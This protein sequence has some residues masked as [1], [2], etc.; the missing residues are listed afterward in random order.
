MKARLLSP[1]PFLSDCQRH[2]RR[3]TLV[4]SLILWAASLFYSAKAQTLYDFGFTR[5]PHLVVTTAQ[6]TLSMPW[7]GGMNAVR[8]S[9]IDLN[10]DG[11]LDIIAFEKHG[12]RILPFLRQGNR[13]VFAPQYIHRF[14]RLH[15]W[16]I[17]HDYNQD[18]KAD[19]FTYGLAG[20]SVYKNISQDTLAFELLTDQL[21]AQYYDGPVNI[22]ASPDD[23]PVIADVDGDGRTDILNFWV[24]GKYVH[25]LRNYSTDPDIFDLRLEN[26]CWGH[27]AEAADNNTISLFT[28]CDNKS[29]DE[30]LRHV[31]S[32]LLLHDF[33]GNGLGDLLVGDIDS[34]H[35]I[36]LSNH[37]TPDEARM[38]EQ[39][40]AFPA[41]AP[42]EL[43]SL[44]A[45][46]LVNLPGNATSS[47][48]V[49][50][51]DPSLTKSQDLNSVWRYDYNASL[52]QFTLVQTD[53]LQSDM[54]DVG[55]GCRPVLFDWDNDGLIDLFLA[56]YGTFDSARTV[57]GFVTSSFS[58]SISHYRNVGTSQQPAFQL[59]TRDFGHLR[60]LNLQALH[61][62]FGDLDGDGLPDML[63][64][65]RDGTLTL[66]TNSR[67][68]ANGSPTPG[69]GI[70]PHFQNIDAGDFS[71]PQ[72][73]DLDGDGRKD[74]IIGNRRGLL[75]HYRDTH[76]SGAPFFALV[77]DSLGRVD[78]RDFE[79]SYFGHSVP[80]IYR[81]PQHGTLLFCGNEQGGI[82]YYKDIDNNLDAEFTLA[83]R[84]MA[85]SVNGSACPLRE[86][87]R[88]GVAVA[89][90]NGDGLPDM[91]VGNYAGGC[92]YF[93]GSAPL[94]H[95][96]GLSELTTRRPPYPNPTTGILHIPHDGD[97]ATRATIFD[98]VGR[99]IQHTTGDV[100]DIHLLPAGIY[101]LNVEGMGRWKIVKQP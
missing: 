78:V 79:T 5:A 97:N 12:N 43:L 54:L 49:S 99:P 38:T 39:D 94:P 69:F 26:E 14:P 98:M 42:V 77:T 21:T 22:Y 15:D 75:S 73:Y 92:A 11:S 53:F 17:F 25:F 100:I 8:F 34:P 67:I 18:G 80:C 89:D 35:L 50:P 56:N 9:E 95:E 85:E 13:L 27:F 1:F 32:S 41:G 66:V 62:A 7:A 44:P 58:S 6:D 86:G 52:Q 60:A 93:E 30:P 51:A 3:R 72:L 82:F 63:C 65:Q 59:Q 76:S 101:I 46:A 36:L 45:P 83:E 4:L 64:G 40:T 96:S 20:I 28:D 29:G 88:T 55:S 2:I 16:A 68:N 70:T 24:L 47:L 61:P 33:D 74:L 48:I 31:G 23:Y 91:I 90:L 84:N 71:T 87:K 57:N 10:L 37:G 19:I 81:D